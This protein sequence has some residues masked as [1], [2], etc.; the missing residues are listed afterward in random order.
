MSTA[1]GC[2][3]FGGQLDVVGIAVD[4]GGNEGCC[5]P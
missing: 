4:E 5:S 2:S 1:V 3:L